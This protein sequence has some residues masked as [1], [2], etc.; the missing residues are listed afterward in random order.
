MDELKAQ[1]RVAFPASPYYGP[2]TECT[3]DECTDIKE[4]LRYKRWDELPA[5]FIE[6]TFNTSLISAEAFREFI[7]AYLL[8]ALD[9]LDRKT[10]V[11]DYIIY[12][13]CPYVDED[14]KPPKQADIDKDL[15][16][17]RKRAKGISR[18]QVQAV[19]AFL[20]FV[21]DNASE[22]EC[23]TPHIDCALE[24]VWIDTV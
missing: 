14:D 23:L 17:G 20:E 2:I 19:R 6:W 3:C 8:Y 10:P 15:L 11:L 13:L 21:R 7:P 4:G 24:K 22:H 12:D 5:R 1:I 16:R 9:D 18:E